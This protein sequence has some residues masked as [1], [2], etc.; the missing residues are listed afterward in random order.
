MSRKDPEKSGI[1]F[2]GLFR[3]FPVAKFYDLNYNVVCS[4]IDLDI[5]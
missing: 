3:I 5:K 1:Q 2:S 4:E